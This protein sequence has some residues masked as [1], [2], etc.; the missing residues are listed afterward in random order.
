MIRGQDLELPI[1]DE[2]MIEIAMGLDIEQRRYLTYLYARINKPK[3]AV[4]IGNHVLRENPSDRQTMLVLASLAVEQQQ[5]EEAVRLAKTFLGY[6]PDDHQG[7]YFLG[8]GYYLQRR[9]SE[10]EQVL[11][12]TK[13]NQ[14]RGESY[15]Y[16]TDL[17]SASV[18]AG[19]WYRAMLSYQ[20]LLR[21][22]DLGDELRS[23]VRRELDRIYREHGP[24]IALNHDSIRLESGN[25]HRM[26][27][28][29]RM[30]LTERHW[31]TVTAAND[32]VKIRPRP[33]LIPRTTKRA[34]YATILRS[35]WGSRSHSTLGLGHSPQGLTTEAIWHHNVAPSRSVSLAW[36][37]NKTS[38]D[39]LLL[40][41]LDGRQDRIELTFSWLIEADLNMVLRAFSRDLRVGKTELGNGTG[42]ELSIDQVLRRNGAHWLVG[43]RGSY[44][45]FSTT[46]R[47][48]GV[49]GSALSQGLPPRE[50]AAIFQNLVAPRI[51][52]HGV[53]LVTADEL[54]RA[55]HYRIELGGDYDFERET[56]GYNASMQWIFR[57]RK[58]IELGV[59]GGYFSSADSSDAGSSAYLLDLSF[60]FYY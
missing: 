52:R 43:Y 38:T 50:R 33:G 27:F 11:S 28:A 9:F 19:Q 5:G 32:R 60:L 31:W 48:F 47:N 10:S 36:N 49:L 46:G 7:L 15:P 6:Y 45:S 53:S 16:E 4:R 37:G 30:H 57:P 42:V 35:T 58:S 56:F 12:E 21:N 14:F 40:E 22:H 1:E 2:R 3:V 26:D 54:T 34:D 8:A 23:E 44:A 29:H 24:Q 59:R 20:E 41:S 17:A 55:W 18:G 25:V 39:S 51:N 13:R